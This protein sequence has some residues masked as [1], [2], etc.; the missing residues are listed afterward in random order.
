MSDVRDCGLDSGRGWLVLAGWL[1]P[2]KR[3][4]LVFPTHRK[5]TAL[6]LRLCVAY[7]LSVMVRGDGKVLL[8][9]AIS[10]L[11][12]AVC[13]VRIGHLSFVMADALAVSLAKLDSDMLALLAERKVPDQ[14]SGKLADAG[15]TSVALWAGADETAGGIRTWAKAD[16]ALDLAVR[17]PDRLGLA[18]L[19]DAWQASRMCVQK[20]NEKE[21]EASMAR[22]PAPVPRS[23]M[24]AMRATFQ[25][26]YRKLEEDQ[27]PSVPLLELHFE[28]MAEGEFRAVLLSEVVSVEDQQE[29][30]QTLA[31]DQH[32]HIKVQRAVHKVGPPGNTE[33]LRGR[34]QVLANALTFCKLRFPSKPML[35][36]VTPAILDDHLAFILGKQ[37]YQLKSK[38]LGMDI[39]GPTFEL[40][41]SYEWQIRRKAATLVNEG[42]MSLKDALADAAGDSQLKE[43]HFNTPQLAKLGARSDHSLQLLRSQLVLPPRSA[44]AGTTPGTVDSS[45][46][47]SRF[48][49]H[50][51]TVQRA[52]VEVV[53]ANMCA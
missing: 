40:V 36:E 31:L 23:D 20:R 2:P 53:D 7:T 21:S 17:P 26:H 41:L 16:L 25:Q 35:R 39:A 11:S 24:V 9:V 30:V 18:A 15:F 49:M 1:I 46:G 14:V 42:G 6:P 38:H 51:I 28:M 4:Y 8:S 19:V 44:P 50:G 48:A 32:G 10:D 37:V 29:D 27:L 43:R 33:E 47:V 3:I 52:V 34:L 5:V 45:Q 22:V 12:F 13:A